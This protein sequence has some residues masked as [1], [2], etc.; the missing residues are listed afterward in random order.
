MAQSYGVALRKLRKKRGWSQDVLA[1]KADVSRETVIRAEQS[2]NVGAMLLFQIA[3]ALDV[4]LT[5]S[6]GSSA[7]LAEKPPAVWPRLQR[8]QRVAVLKHAYRL[9]GEAAPKEDLG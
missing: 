6:F 3:D 2:G 9:L 7:Q 1:E 4:D 5:I 8:E